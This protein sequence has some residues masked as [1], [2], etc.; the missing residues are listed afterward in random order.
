V[1]APSVSLLLL[2]G[3]LLVGASA[4][5]VYLT[6][7]YRMGPVAHILAGYEARLEHHTSFLM[8]SFRGAQ[9]ARL[10]LFAG[11][12]VVV[13]WGTT[14][15]PVFGLLV[16]ALAVAPPTVLRRQHEARVAK[17]EAQLDTWLLLL[18][19]ALKATSSVGEAIASTVALAPRPF[20]EEIDLLVKEI[21]L[22]VP[23][24]RALRSTGCRIGSAMISGALGAIIV[25]RQTG[26]DLP[27]T[28]DRAAAALR[29]SARLEGVLRAKTA[30]GRGQV[31]VLAAVPFV[32]C[33]IIA[34][35]D[36]HWFDPMFDHS[37]GRA[38]LL[39][40]TL[41]WVVAVVWAH[42]IVRADL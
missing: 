31:F 36:R 15:H 13:L 27:G 10:Q 3:V 14:R 34:W 11:S 12:V 32:L 35:L 30:E 28:L 23:L 7:A 8:S 1:S 22:G 33:V 41:S 4:T 6:L 17:L 29:E 24:D 38:I 25:A 2:G 39:G 5:L 26:G 37:S 19:N 20:R 40:C 21:R 42:S 9:I 18:A 16:I